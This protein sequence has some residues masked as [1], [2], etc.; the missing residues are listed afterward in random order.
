MGTP[1]IRILMSAD[2]DSRTCLLVAIMY[3]TSV[4]DDVVCSADR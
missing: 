1:R 2:V 3:T 4:A